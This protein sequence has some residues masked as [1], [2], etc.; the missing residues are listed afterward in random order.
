MQ[1]VDLGEA[2][3]DDHVRSFERGIAII[4]ALGEHDS[5]LTAADL[6]DLAGVP[7]AAARRFLFTLV[8]LGYARSSGRLYSLRPTVLELGNAYLTSSRIGELALPAMR[9]LA[10]QLD[11]A[12]ALSVL[13]DDEIVYLALARGAARPVV[14]LNVMI[15]SRLPAYPT[16]MGRVLLAGQSDDWRDGYLAR[17][18]LRPMTVNTIQSPPRLRSVLARVAKNGYAIV[19]RELDMN[20]YSAAVPVRSQDGAV[21]AALN[22]STHPSRRPQWPDRDELISMLRQT[23]TQIER[24]LSRS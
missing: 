17:T 15:G 18:T 1:Q 9:E 8:T 23:A 12:S 19:D 10:G 21:L 2:A 22:I 7:R 14:G 13:A 4:R 3:R 5:E 16:A 24:R 6:A 20:I 11:D